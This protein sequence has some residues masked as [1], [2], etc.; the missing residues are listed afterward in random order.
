[1]VA[2]KQA[3]AIP[4]PWPTRA[5]L[6]VCV[7]GAPVAKA[8]VRA[9]KRIAE[10]GRASWIVASVVTPQSESLPESAK[11]A[12]ADTLRLAESL[13]AETATIHAEAH[14]AD[15]ILDFARSR[16]VTRIVP[17]RPRPRPLLRPE[18]RRAGK[19]GV[20]TV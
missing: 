14:I 11:D 13:G 15:E 16:N 18:E 6:L 12:I 5:R 3:H 4:G 2:H 9:A 20:R 17:G 8:L 7:N 1:M 19:K 10:R